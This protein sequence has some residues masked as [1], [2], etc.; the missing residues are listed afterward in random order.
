MSF[1]QQKAECKQTNQPNFT[2]HH[3]KLNG[4]T[5]TPTRE[6]VQERKTKEHTGVKKK[7]K[8]EKKRKTTTA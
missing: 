8:N 2:L 5:S 3:K 4:I 7:E 6:Q 1:T